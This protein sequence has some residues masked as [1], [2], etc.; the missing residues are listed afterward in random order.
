MILKLPSLTT[1]QPK[2]ALYVYLTT[3]KEAVSAV[4][5]AERKGR[6]YPV[7]YV[8]RTLH[9]A[10][11]NYAPLEKVALALLHVSRRLRRYFEAHPIT[12]ITYRPIKQILNK[13]KSSGRLAKYSVELRA[14]NISYEPRS[15]IKGQI[16]YNRYLLCGLKTGGQPDKR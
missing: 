11:R 4:L 13:A 9:D 6:Q 3:S 5:M 10:E 8:S 16:R 15:A 2:E 1:P 7:H 14:Y 12:V